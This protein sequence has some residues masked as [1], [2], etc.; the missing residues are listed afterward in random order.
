MTGA[1]K[2]KEIIKAY[3]TGKHLRKPRAAM[4]IPLEDAKKLQGE[5][6]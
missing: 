1:S 3:A 5:K 4:G 2:E 6:R